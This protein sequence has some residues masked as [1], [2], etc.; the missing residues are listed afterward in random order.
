ME[1]AEK[2]DTWQAQVKYI[3]YIK[4]RIIN[5]DFVKNNAH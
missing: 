5:T 3:I 4:K 1:I 2:L